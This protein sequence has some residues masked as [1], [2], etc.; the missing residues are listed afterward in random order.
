M[1]KQDKSHAFV[2]RG[3]TIG[4][5]IEDIREELQ[6]SS[7]L[8]AREIFLIKTKNIPLYFIVTDPAITLDYSI[9]MF[10]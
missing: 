3:M 4:T 7:E 5:D 2:L 10:E 1:Q 9:K 8:T 6:E